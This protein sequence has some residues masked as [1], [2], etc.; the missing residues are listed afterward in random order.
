M[1]TVTPMMQQYLDIKEQYKDCI[2][3]FRLG[4]FY[5]MFFEDAEIASKELEIALTGRDCGLEERAPMCGVPFHAADTYIAKLINKG[6]KVAICEQ[7]E[8]PAV[9]KG[10]VRRDVIRI[11]TP[12]TVTDSSMLDERRNNYLMSIHADRGYYGIAIVDITTGEFLTTSIIYGNTEGKLYDEIAKYAP[13]EIILSCE[14]DN[15]E[16]INNIKKRYNNI[17]ISVFDQTWFEGGTP[18]KKLAEKFG[19]KKCE[20]VGMLSNYSVYASGILLEYLERT[21]KVNLEHIQDIKI[22]R[23]DEYMILDETAR[24]NLELTETMREK[25]RKGSLLNVM[26]RTVTSMGGRMIRKWIEQPLI[27]INDINSRLDAVSELK[28]KFMLRM[29]IRELLKKVYDMERLIGKVVLGNANCRDLIALKNSTA[30]LPYIKELMSN[31]TSSLLVQIYEKTDTLDDICEL[32]EKSIVDDP[33]VT[34]KEGG[35]IKTGYNEEVDRLRKASTEGKSW[36]AALENSERERTG[37]K[38]LKVGFNKVFGYYLEVTKSHLSLVPDNYIRKQTL[39]N[40]ERYITDELKKI[41]DSILGAEEKVVQLE[42][43]IFME[44]R[45]KISQQTGRIKNTALQ[46]SML[47]AL[48]SL[49]ELADRE[50]YCMPVVDSGDAIE[51]IDGRH[52]VV[53]KMMDYGTFVPNDTILDMDENRFLIITGPNMAG[54]STYMRQTALIVLMAQ[55]GSFVPA[56]RAH[57]GIVDRIFTRVGASD[58]LASGQSTFM[59]EMSEVA[60][61]LNNATPRSLLILDEIGRGTSTYDGL[62]IAWAVTEFIANKEKMGCRT[63]FATHYHELTELEGKLPG[64]KNYCISVQEKGDDIIF[65]R[66]IIRGGADESYGVQVAKLAGI[67]VPIIERAKE[68]LKELEDSDIS[69][70]VSRLRR[71]V[72]PA[73]G[74]IDIFSFMNTVN[75]NNEVLEELKNIDIREMTPI[76]ALN[77]LYKLQQKV[78]KGI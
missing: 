40:C 20:T 18:E 38:N 43:E 28:E 77:C 36:V 64:I 78:K 65:L 29:E 62:S 1:A 57:I 35:I 46:I 66:K 58:D 16:I 8:D 9:A 45:N 24:R 6:Y 56:G 47:D 17:Y 72:K 52:P 21:Q 48:C 68:I 60:D 33:P 39:A 73:E 31:C 41:E 69:R 76:D 61:I 71:G 30:Q 7:V 67:P 2:L 44:I 54:K 42:Y 11:I 51:I 74:Q 49:A 37:I 75:G 13:S 26:D 3:F 22:Y 19:Q 15:Y 25:K 50:N 4:D 12:G 27:N 59:V 23:I 53:E 55:I 32:I 34:I 10:I 63:L 5:E 70:K 14:S